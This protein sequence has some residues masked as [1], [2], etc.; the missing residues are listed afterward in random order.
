[1]CRRTESDLNA[2]DT[3]MS[4]HQKTAA[5]RTALQAITAT[6]TCVAAAYAGLLL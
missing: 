1:M 6:M 4:K 3:P 5:I 2:G